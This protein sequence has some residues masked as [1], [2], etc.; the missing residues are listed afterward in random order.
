[1]KTRDEKQE[2]ITELG[3]FLKESSGIA[4]CLYQGLTMKEMAELRVKIR[5]FGAK[6]MVVK[7]TLA[8]IAAKGTA[9]EEAVADL[10]G[11][12]SL[13]FLKDDTSVALKTLFAFS[14]DHQFFKLEKGNIEKNALNAVGLKTFSE[15]PTRDEVRAMFLGVLQAS[16]SRFVGVLAGPSREFVG[17]LKANED[18]LGGKQAA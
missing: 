11:P 5:P 2:I 4:I 18:K 17:V 10:T 3:K 13:V 14:R 6:F 16:A 7:N 8:R 12:N 15:L 9:F 1:M